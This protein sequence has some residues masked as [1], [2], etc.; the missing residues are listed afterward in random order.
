M[1]LVVEKDKPLDPTNIRLL[2]FGAEM[3]GTDGLTDA[4]EELGLGC[5]W[6]RSTLHGSWHILAYRVEPVV[7]QACYF[8]SLHEI[9]LLIS[10]SRGSGRRR[11]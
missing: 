2:C 1:S 4:V 6:G 11:A 3:S 7:N 10:G 9:S 5:A 8:G